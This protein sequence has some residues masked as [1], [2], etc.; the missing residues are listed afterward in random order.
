MTDDD[1][2][3][4]PSEHPAVVLGHVGEGRVLV[5]VGTT[6]DGSQDYVIAGESGAGA[7]LVPET[8]F[9]RDAVRVVDAWVP[10]RDGRGVADVDLM[11]AIRALLDDE[12][13]PSK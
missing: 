6:S 4:D 1:P 7:R 8:Y 10:W 9:Y 12:P 2:Q 13:D 5:I 3:R 11:R